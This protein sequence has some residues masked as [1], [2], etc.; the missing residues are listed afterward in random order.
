MIQAK[1]TMR[2]VSFFSA[3][4]FQP[5]LL[6]VMRTFL[7]LFSALLLSG[8]FSARAVC[9]SAPPDI[10]GYASSQAVAAVAV[11]EAESSTTTSWGSTRA[12]HRLQKFLRRVCRALPVGSDGKIDT[13]S[14]LSVIFGAAALISL[15]FFPLLIL[16]SIPALI[17]G[18]VGLGRVKRDGTKGK[19][20][21]IAGIVTGGLGILVM[22]AGL[23]ALILV[24]AFF[25]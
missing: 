23:V 25:L 12:G 2:C 13:S 21:A 3:G 14:L 9:K 5:Q 8:S 18:I 6:H 17:L 20:L 22:L 10:R 15:S 16:L 1:Q 7:L 19:G 4:C 24:I 11:M